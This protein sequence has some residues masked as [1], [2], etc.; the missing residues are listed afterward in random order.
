MNLNLKREVSSDMFSLS[1]LKF[2]RRRLNSQQC[3][4]AEGAE[5]KEKLNPNVST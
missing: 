1:Y 2:P 5:G 3:R 4:L